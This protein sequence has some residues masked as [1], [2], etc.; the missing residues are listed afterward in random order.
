MGVGKLDQPLD[1]GDR[2]RGKPLLNFLDGV[3][4]IVAVHDGVGHNAR[5]A[6]DG[7]PRYL[8][9]NLLDRLTSQPIDI[10]IDVRPARARLLSGYP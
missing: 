5:A 1:L 3:A 6:H 7:P 2:E 9:G 8:A 10:R 4:E